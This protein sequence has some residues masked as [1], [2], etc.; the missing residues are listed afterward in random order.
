VTI[1]LVGLVLLLAAGLWVAVSKL[2]SAREQTAQALAQSMARGIKDAA[3]KKAQGIADAA[4]K[5]VQ[6]ASDDDLERRVRDLA[7]RDRLP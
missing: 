3:E 1:L 6:N 7:R 5:E 4:V 2:L